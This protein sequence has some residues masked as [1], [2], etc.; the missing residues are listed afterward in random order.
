MYK[1]D[2]KQFSESFHADIASMAHSYEMLR[3]H[4]FVEKMSEILIEYGEIGGC[5][6][7]HFKSRGVKIDAYDFD[8]EFTSLTLI[9]SH[10]TD[11]DDPSEAR[12]PE[13]KLKPLIERGWR[14]FRGALAG[15]IQNRIDISNPAFDLADTIYGCRKDLLSV[16]L[17][18]LTDG[19]TK[20]RRART[21]IYEGIE[22]KAVVW[23]ISR[24]HEFIQTGERQQI[25]IDLKGDHGGPI[26]CLEMPSPD[27]LYKTYLAFIPGTI[28][29]DLYREYKIRLLE[30]NVRVFLSQRP[31][32]NRGIRDTILEE[33]YMFC[34]Y[35]NGITVSAKSV[36]LVNMSENGFGIASIS[37]FQI[38]NG[39]QTTASL[40]H[41]REKLKADLEKI[42][43]QMKLMVINDE[44]KP[45]FLAEGQKLSDK[46][47]PE[48]GKYSNTQNRIQMADL[49]A[50]DPPHPELH[51]ISLHQAA[52]DPTGGSQESCWFYEKARGSY[53]ETQRLEARTA[54]KKKLFNQKY[55][56]KQRFDKNKFGKAWN[57]YLRKPHVV[58]L[59]AMKNFAHFNEWL[60]NQKEVD[61]QAFFRK[62]VALVMIWNHAELIV[63]RQ[64][65]GGYTHAIVTYTL[66]WLHHLTETRID[67]DRLWLSQ[68]LDSEV[69]DAIERLS[70]E[71]NEHIRDTRLNVTEWCKKPECWKGLL[72]RIPPRLPDLQPVFKAGQKKIRYDKN[73]GSDSKDIVFC[74]E[75]GSDAW[76]ELSRWLKERDFMPGK[77]RSQCNNMGRAITMKGK[78]PSAILSAACRK[79]WEEAA[80]GMG[81][82]PDA[83]NAT[84][85]D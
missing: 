58:S 37:G 39:G 48:I 51:S 11:Y 34:A 24:I 46:L 7:A 47:V 54:A 44:K 79:I 14:F 62:T 49:L 63:R 80:D 81:W 21:A 56:R 55:P 69:L 45:D 15:K 74:K 85:E 2:L 35:N 65:Y 76:F 19:L 4:A 64:K 9:I 59:G 10:W 77:P 38:V 68:N 1:G 72:E 6:P 71:V 13:S 36:E 8:E 5:E 3:E 17:L 31:L 50:N 32:V 43:V 61:W 16:K 60:Q 52:P 33:P 41:T 18:F 28:L 30:Q 20:R 12:F 82:E 42:A 75:K 84:T 26:P 40:Y 27:G 70:V 57:S 73:G 67:L 29:A 78:K 23:D 66:S 83:D 53:E 25:S 22:V